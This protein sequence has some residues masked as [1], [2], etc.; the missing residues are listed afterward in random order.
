MDIVTIKFLDGTEFK[1]YRDAL[2]ENAPDTIFS[3][4][5]G[6]H[7]LFNVGKDVLPMTY[8]LDRDVTIFKEYIDPYL[9]GYGKVW[10]NEL[11]SPK[12]LKML[13]HDLFYY[14]IDEDDKNEKDIEY[15]SFNDAIEIFKFA[16]NKKIYKFRLGPFHFKDTV[17]K[18]VYD[19]IRTENKD[20]N[21]ISSEDVLEFTEDADVRVIDWINDSPEQKFFQAVFNSFYTGEREEWRTPIDLDLTVDKIPIEVCILNAFKKGQCIP[22]LGLTRHAIAR[23][24]LGLN[25]DDGLFIHLTDFVGCFKFNGYS[26]RENKFFIRLIIDLDHDGPHIQTIYDFDNL[27]PCTE[28]V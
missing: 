12:H 17:I 11:I 6:E 28:S 26:K 21:F 10:K 14:G 25:K 3:K 7:S 23:S 27:V 8:T 20:R 9:R 13:E 2:S 18:L 1:Y 19:V 16:M 4:H 22:A 15:M 5:F 24:G